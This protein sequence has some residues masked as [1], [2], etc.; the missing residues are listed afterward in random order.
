MWCLYVIK[1]D[2]YKNIYT[3]AYN[4]G[5][6]GGGVFSPFCVWLKN[7]PPSNI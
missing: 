3:C 4:W 2:D 1:N 5:G 6:G 7:L